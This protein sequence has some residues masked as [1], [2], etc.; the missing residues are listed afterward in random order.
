MIKIVEKQRLYVGVWNEKKN[1]SGN[2]KDILEYQNQ[3]K[4]VNFLLKYAKT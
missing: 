2:E 3:C 4:Y 1:K